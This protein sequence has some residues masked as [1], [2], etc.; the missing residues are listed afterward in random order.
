MSESEDRIYEEALEIKSG[1]EEKK[2]RNLRVK[3][4]N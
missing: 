1:V 2:K 4:K 3:R